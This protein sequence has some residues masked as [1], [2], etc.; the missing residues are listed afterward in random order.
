MAIA[1]AFKSSQCIDL[2]SIDQIKKRLVSE[3]ISK[4][5]CNII[6]VDKF[7]SYISWDRIVLLLELQSPLENLVELSLCQ[8]TSRMRPRTTTHIFL[9]TK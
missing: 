8:I 1:I 6:V 7:V 3:V 5:P 4:Y 2:E 9:G